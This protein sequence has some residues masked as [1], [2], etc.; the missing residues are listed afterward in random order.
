M[1]NEPELPIGAVADLV[2][3]ATSTL[4]YYERRGLV[5]SDGRASGQRRYHWPTVRRLVF[6]RMLQD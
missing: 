1:E 2:G 4:R 6:I 3:V 5:A